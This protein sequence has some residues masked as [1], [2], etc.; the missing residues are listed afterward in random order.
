MS[1][2]WKSLL[3][4]VILLFITSFAGKRM[5]HPEIDFAM[6]Y[7]HHAKIKCN[8]QT[9]SVTVR[10]KRNEGTRSKRFVFGCVFVF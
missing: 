6:S 7:F 1:T 2:I 9:C 5:P 8:V 3:F 4:H 10:D